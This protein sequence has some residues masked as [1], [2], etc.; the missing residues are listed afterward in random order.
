MNDRLA[1]DPAIVDA[2]DFQPQMRRLTFFLSFG[3][4]LTKWEEEG[5]LDREIL[6]PAT[7][8]RMGYFDDVAIFTYHPLDGEVLDG[9]AAADPVFRRLTL[10]LPPGQVADSRA[11]KLVWSLFGPLRHRGAIARSSVMKTNQISGSWAAI[12]AK[13]LT[14][15]PLILRLGYLLSRRHRLNGKGFAAWVSALVER[16]GYRLADSIVVTSADA[17]DQVAMQSGAPQKV[18]LVPTYVDPTL[19][20]A[21]THYDF[22]APILYVGR[23]TPQKNLVNLVKACAA[24]KRELHLVGT[25]E[26]Q[27]QLAAV[28]QDVGC[29]LAFLGRVPNTELARLMQ[30]YT[31]F[32][33]PSLHEGLP[34]VLIE[35]MACGMICVG[36]DVPGTHDLIVDGVNGYLARGTSAE[37]IAAALARAFSE[38][39]TEYGAAARRLI[40]QK[41]GIE[42][43]ARAEAAIL[44]AGPDALAGRDERIGTA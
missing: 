27:E 44:L 32:A 19:F 16:I 7:L 13:L 34:K 10:L 8:L 2:S 24:L 15:R 39:R 38:Q 9:L 26:Q 30:G 35:A 6:L 20:A 12:I 29:R 40:E 21:K 4:S 18:H 14:G 37:A 1:T 22:S 3:G 25:G 42:Q 11:L 36:T 17:R 5:I 41:F 28:A 43:Y 31:V 23:F 33:L